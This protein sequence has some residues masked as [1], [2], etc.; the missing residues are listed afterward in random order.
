MVRCSYCTNEIEKGSGIMYVR[1]TGAIKYYCSDRCYKFEVVQHKK[2][3]VK[4]Q[5]E[6]AKLQ[7]KK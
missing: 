4:E 2:Q 5:R 6:T 1:K 3:R 7:S